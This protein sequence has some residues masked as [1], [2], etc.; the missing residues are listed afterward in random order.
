MEKMRSL[1]KVKGEEIVAGQKGTIEQ[2]IATF[3]AAQDVREASRESYR[4]C[5]TQ[6]FEWVVESGRSI[7]LLTRQDVLEYK[8]S[9]LNKGLTPLS[10][11]SYLGAV[12]RFY[13][14]AEGEK[15]YPN[16]AA[17]IHN[18]KKSATFKRN[19]L[20]EDKSK[21][22]LSYYQ[23]QGNLRDFAI[24]NLILR[25]G[26]RTIEVVRLNVEDITFKGEQRVI[27]IWGKGRDTK[28]DFVILSDKAY[29][30]IKNYLA[31]RKGVRG[32]EPLFVSSSVR[33]MGERLTT[34]SI[35]MICKDG[36]VAV[37]LD[38]REFCSHAL[39]HTTA[40]LLLKNGASVED[41]QGVLR[42]TSPAT[43]QIYLESIKEDMRLEKAA[44]KILDGVF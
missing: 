8:D 43:T 42:H 36:L 44:E 39:R 27:K 5:I 7:Q 18:P 31:T 2:I 21:E 32:G 13:T 24:V 11:C 14:W 40:C 30:P 20:T 22:L 38:G 29:L 25:C 33:N 17:D 3:V 6:Y 28:E 41:V 10:V 16:I 23:E 37:G 15:M 26:L 12:R 9:L 35:R 34:R 19:H 1:V 4:K